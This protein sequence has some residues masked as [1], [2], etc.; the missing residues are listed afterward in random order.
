M[1]DS[2]ADSIKHGF[3]NL[4]ADNRNQFTPSFKAY[5]CIK[6][7]FGHFDGTEDPP[8]Q[9]DPDDPMKAEKKEMKAY[10]QDCAS[11]AGYLWLCINK[12]QHTH[13]GLLRGKPEV[14]WSKLKDIHQQQKLGTQFNAYDILFSI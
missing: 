6:R 14:M 13:V 8:E 10:L 5:M 7:L 3:P 1:L 9:V 2:D 4:H 12:S 11:T